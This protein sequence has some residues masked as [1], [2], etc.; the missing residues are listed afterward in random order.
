MSRDLPR[1]R[2]LRVS[3]LVL[4]LSLICIGAMSSANV[5]NQ[6]TFTLPGAIERKLKSGP[7]PEYPA[8]ARRL[9]ISGVAKVV[10]T[11]SPKGSVIQVRELGGN[12]I[13]VDALM[14]A[15]QTW[16]YEPSSDLSTIEVKFEFKKSSD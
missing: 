9:N 15:V 10:A 7:P 4:F 8:L 16:T 12:P 5:S 6:G 3:H 1:V 11:V 2:R 13:L 14:R